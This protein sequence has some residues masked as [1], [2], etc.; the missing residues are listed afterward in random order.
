MTN[1]TIRIHN[2]QTNEVIDREMTHDEAA[3]YEANQKQKVAD[4]KAAADK[5][6][7]REAVFAKLGLTADEVAA[8]LG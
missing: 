3:F 5:V 4:E 6:A 1:P 7:A 2:S 8:L